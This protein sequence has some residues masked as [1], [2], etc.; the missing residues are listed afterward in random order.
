MGRFADYLGLKGGFDGVLRWVLDLRKRLGVP[1]TIAGLGVDDA[2]IEL[3]SAMAVQDPSAAGN[4]VELTA[5]GARAIFEAAL[6]GVL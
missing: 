1:H 5:S 4:P 2:Q 3:I 6:E